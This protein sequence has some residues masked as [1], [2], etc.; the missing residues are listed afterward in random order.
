M[1]WSE[2]HV[3][4]PE[5]AEETAR[6]RRELCA[7]LRQRAVVHRPG[8]EN[9]IRRLHRCAGGCLATRRDSRD[10][11]GTGHCVAARPGLEPGVYNI[12]RAACQSAA[13]AVSP[14]YEGRLVE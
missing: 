14:R 11:R 4:L 3:G 10:S 5:L 2:R 9:T 12:H 8:L 7:A 13:I 6:G 1:E